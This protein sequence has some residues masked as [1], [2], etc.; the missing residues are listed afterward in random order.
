MSARKFGG[1]RVA[2]RDPV[3]VVGAGAAGLAAATSLTQAGW[4]TVVLES[5]DRVGGR[6]HTSTTSDG[7]V[8]D[9]GAMIIASGYTNMLEHVIN[10]GLVDDLVPVDP[11]VGFVRDDTIHTI[12]TSR[13]VRSGVSSKLLGLGSKLRLT[14]ALLDSRRARRL[15]D[16]EDLSS[17]APVD[18]ESA[19]EYAARRL[20]PEIYDYL[21][22]ASVRGLLGVSAERVSVVDFFYTL[23]K[24]LGARLFVP[25][26]GLSSYADRLASALDVRTS[27]RVL[28]VIEEPSGVR[29]TWEEPDGT[30]RVEHGAAAVLAV[31]GDRVASIAPLLSSTAAEFLGRLRYA[32]TV[33]VKLELSHPPPDVPIFMIVVPRPVHDG[34]FALSLDH[35]LGGRVP[36]GKGL[37]GLYLMSEWAERLADEDDQVIVDAALEAGEI[38]LPGISASVEQARVTRWSPSV[39]YSRPGL[40]RELGDFTAHRPREKIHLA[41]DYFS[42]SNLNTATAAG[43]RAAREL[44]DFLEGNP[45]TIACSGE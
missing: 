40:Y 33:T 11:R 18:V 28:E 2:E 4:P 35:N 13:L 44:T 19:A 24:L 12:D 16:D 23:N 42:S 43:D 25:R 36:E 14:N 32:S 34:V 17:A 7:F 30:H 8:V 6:M 20:N 26:N 31:P 15:L 37:V 5:S 39:V 27:S 38:A 41:G 1:T 10:A 3:F 22:D 45:G 9:D 21:V 29:V